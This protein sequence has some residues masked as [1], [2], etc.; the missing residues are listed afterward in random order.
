MRTAVVSGFDGTT[1][2]GR[3][4][5]WAAAES[6]AEHRPLHIVHALQL[7][8]DELTRVHLPSEAPVVGP[9]REAAQ[10]HTSEIAAQC[11]HRWPSLEVR[12]EVRVGDPLAVL[13]RAAQDAALLVLGAPWHSQSSRVLLGVT[14]AKLVRAAKIPV[15]VVRNA[16]LTSDKA[17]PPFGRIAVGVDGSAASA[18]AIDFAFA[19]ASRHGSELIAV[20]AWDR[21][22]MDVLSRTPMSQLTR[23]QIIAECRRTLSES[24][25][26]RHFPDVTVRSQVTVTDRPEQAL[27]TMAPAVDLLVVGSHGRGAV[28]SALVGSVSRSVL[29]YAECPVAVIPKS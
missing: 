5:L 10:A 7:P 29:H 21:V 3:A 1:Q 20:H 4:V 15:V 25:A 14:P 23:D 22:P 19:F 26:G 6:A 8:L 13:S 11:Q 16:R 17:A 24:L 9:L 18:Q 2:S 27:L 28:L 12:T